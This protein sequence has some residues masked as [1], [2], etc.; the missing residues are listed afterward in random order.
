MLLG[1]P[2]IEKDQAKKHEAEKDLEQ[3]R[4]ELR[5]IT[6][7]RIAQLIEEQENRSRFLDPGNLDD[8]VDRM[9]EEPK[10]TEKCVGQVIL[11]DLKK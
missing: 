2:W 10:R 5:D 8:K 7:R 6:T 11:V 3:Q 1:K 9:L 4:Q